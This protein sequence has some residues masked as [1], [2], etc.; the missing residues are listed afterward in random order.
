MH[1]RLQESPSA[2]VMCRQCGVNQSVA[3][4]YRPYS[5]L[6]K[7]TPG[8]YTPKKRTW[9]ELHGLLLKCRDPT[10]SATERKRI[11]AAEGL[12]RLW[13]AMDPELVPHVNP[14]EDHLQDG[15]HLFGDGL[16][17][18]HAAWMLHPLHQLG[19]QVDSVNTAM[20]SYKGFPR[21]VHIPKIH[22]GITKGC[23]GVRGNLPRAEAVLRMTGS[24]VHHWAL[25]RCVTPAQPSPALP[26]PAKPNTDS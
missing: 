2:H 12:K 13:F 16:L 8:V 26:N 21:D 1:A 24:E 9:P 20:R 5:F 25:H 19:L 4:A 22:E 10:T 11:M 15:L 7:E 23:A 17:R 18:S 3:G 6:R 14:C